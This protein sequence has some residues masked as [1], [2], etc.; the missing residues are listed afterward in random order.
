MYDL[1]DR[2]LVNRAVCLSIHY[3][4]DRDIRSDTHTFTQ[5]FDKF[6]RLADSSPHVP[7]LKKKKYGDYLMTSAEWDLLELIKEVLQVHN[8]FVNDFYVI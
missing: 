5:A 7:L 8:I 2:A 1:I 4:A 3:W 6:C